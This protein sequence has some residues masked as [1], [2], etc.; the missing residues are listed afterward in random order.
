MSKGISEWQSVW[1][2]G[3]MKSALW[4]L[5]SFVALLAHADWTP[6]THATRDEA[7]KI[8]KEAKADTRAGRYEDS[9]AKHVWYHQNALKIDRSFCAVRLTFD[10]GDWVKLGAAYPRH[11]TN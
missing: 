11:W 2:R 9:L 6:P 8:R 1:Q 3:F 10:L 7:D 4:A 5:F